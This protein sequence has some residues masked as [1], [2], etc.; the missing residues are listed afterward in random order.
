MINTTKDGLKYLVRG[1]EIDNDIVQILKHDE[2][3]YS[4]IKT[5]ILD[6]Y[7]LNSD[8]LDNSIIV[9]SSLVSLIRGSNILNSQ[10]LDLICHKSNYIS[11][12]KK[13][14][15]NDYFRHSNTFNL[16]SSNIVDTYWD[17]EGEECIEEFRSLRKYMYKIM[18]FKNRYDK[19]LDLIILYDGYDY[20]DYISKYDLSICQNYLTNE[21]LY[22]FDY[23]N[24][25]QN[26]FL[27]LYA[28][29]NINDIRINI[30][31]IK[32]IIKYLYYLK[33][34]YKE[35]NPIVIF[36]NNRASTKD[37]LLEIEDIKNYFKDGTHCKI[38]YIDSCYYHRYHKLKL[39]E[40]KEKHKL[41]EGSISKTDFEYDSDSDSESDYEE[42]KSYV[43]TT[44]D[45]E[46]DSDSD[47]E[48]EKSESEFI[49]DTKT[50]NTKIGKARKGLNNIKNIKRAKCTCYECKNRGYNE[51]INIKRRKHKNMNYEAK[52]VS[53]F[54]HNINK[55]PLFILPKNYNM[56][57]IKGIKKVTI[58]R[59]EY[60]YNKCNPCSTFYRYNVNI[61]YKYSQ[62]KVLN[63]LNYLTMNSVIHNMKSFI[64]YD[65]NK[66]HKY[67]SAIKIIN[68]D[69]ED[70]YNR[71]EHDK[72]YRKR[73]KVIPIN[74]SLYLYK[75]LYHSKYYT[76]Y[77]PTFKKENIGIY[78][79]EYLYILID[80]FVID[81]N[82]INVK[83][84]KSYDDL[85]DLKN[86]NDDY[87]NNNKNIDFYNEID[88]YDYLMR[89]KSYPEFPALEY[90]EKFLK[91]EYNYE[92][93]TDY[94]C[95]VIC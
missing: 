12:M 22:S 93:L 26:E 52:M 7:D 88:N 62:I 55:D 3:K 72:E 25:K 11:V 73:I 10:D 61:H 32:R 36:G 51:D 75:D 8:I 82:S 40:S 48:S 87:N 43:T 31:N 41:K 91:S 54:Y 30:K 9:G 81:F 80:R 35:V 74:F 69:N 19:Y 18:T 71:H 65:N 28:V 6:Y 90:C 84:L 46:S 92:N 34:I 57:N 39:K 95:L 17:S 20:I 44:S 2:D 59:N 77:F 23:P 66:D 89:K 56:F 21:G 49:I 68:C 14:L 38:C 24:L 16:N 5:S 42:E 64:I 63:N 79:Y 78:R 70:K 47:S 27:Y 53:N 37:E 4:S 85:L 83:V 76:P 45:S 50:Y 29:N 13:L 94:L 58:Y 1:S 67:I 60:I 33:N 15:D 86:T